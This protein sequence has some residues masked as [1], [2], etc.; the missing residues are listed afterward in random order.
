MRGR[1]VEAPIPVNMRR[2]RPKS[3]P[4]GRVRRRV[5][6]K[7]AIAFAEISSL[8]LDRNRVRGD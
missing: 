4:R 6:I 1:S 7:R 8:L 5:N 3:L 2:G